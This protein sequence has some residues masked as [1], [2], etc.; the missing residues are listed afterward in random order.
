MS[1]SS[2]DTPEQA[3]RTRIRLEVEQVAKA[4]AL[5]RIDPTAVPVL[6]GLATEPTPESIIELIEKSYNTLDDAKQEAAAYLLSNTPE[7]WRRTYKAR[8]ADAAT[9]LGVGSYN[10]FRDR[11]TVDGLSHH[12]RLLAQV[13]DA[14]E[15]RF[16]PE[17]PQG[18]Q[19]EPHREE[20]PRTVLVGVFIAVVVIVIGGVYLALSGNERKVASA[21]N[22]GMQVDGCDIPVAGST[23]PSVIP[24]D[25]EPVMVS[26]FTKLGEAAGLGCPQHGVE[27]WGDLWLQHFIGGDTRPRGFLVTDLN[28]SVAMWVEWSIVEEYRSVLNGQLDSEGGLPKAT[29][30]LDGHHVL[31]LSKGGLLIAHQPGGPAFWIPGEAVEVWQQAGGPTGELGLPMTDVRFQDG[32]PHQDF[33]HGHISEGEPL[34]AQAHLTGQTDTNRY[35]TEIGAFDEGILRSID[36]TAWWIDKR[37]QRHWIPDGGV[38]N[39]LGGDT[40][41]IDLETPGWVI[42]SFPPSSNASCEG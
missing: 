20:R 11:K 4:R 41:L 19:P 38:W 6:A 3:R 10:T 40:T 32:R 12:D 35:L 7:R 17:E 13:A 22:L 9:R 24:D 31:R 39:C 28:Q 14:I 2:G 1:T 42:G 33:E 25:L 34:Q 23:N 26:V 37:G 18:E 16:K 36:G 15:V 27:R 21:Q 5:E 30:E 29:S 8:S